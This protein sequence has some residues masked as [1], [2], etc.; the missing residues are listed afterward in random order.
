MKALALS[1]LYGPPYRSVSTLKVIE[2]L[3]G[4]VCS[5]KSSLH[6]CRL[7]LGSTF[8]LCLWCARSSVEFMSS[9]WQKQMR[10]ET[11]DV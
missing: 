4:R 9:C 5:G 7:V 8:V 2:D 11:N 6:L 10:T 3:E 1:I